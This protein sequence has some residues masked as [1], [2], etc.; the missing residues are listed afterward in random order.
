[1]ITERTPCTA[2]SIELKQEED[3]NNEE[4]F[5]SLVTPEHRSFKD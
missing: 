3:I 4:R 1:M 5:S 2:R